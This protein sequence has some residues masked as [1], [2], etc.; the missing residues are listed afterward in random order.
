[1]LYCRW[2]VSRG[3]L[4]AN[5]SLLAGSSSEA[6]NS[7]TTLAGGSNA[8][9]N[10]SAGDGDQ[11]RRLLAA[12]GGGSSS[13]G[14]SDDGASQTSSFEGYKLRTQAKLVIEDDTPP[15]AEVPRRFLG[16]VDGRNKLIGGLMLHTAREV[17]NSDCTGGA[18][19]IFVACIQCFSPCSIKG[20]NRFTGR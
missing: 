1:M 6:A 2:N 11:R 18:A 8:A 14:R 7:N 17:F 10:S 5:T 9:E 13:V 16:A 20:I 12:V 15:G 4:V 19:V 3:A